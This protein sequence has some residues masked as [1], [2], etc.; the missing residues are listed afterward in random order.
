MSPRH[1]ETSYALVIRGSEDDILTVRRKLEAIA[2]AGGCEVVH[3]KVS[4]RRLLVFEDPTSPHDAINNRADQGGGG[5]ERNN[6]E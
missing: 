2:A 3:R 1:Y 6:P 5:N 4:D